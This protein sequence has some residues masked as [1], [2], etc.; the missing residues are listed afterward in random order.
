MQVECIT[1]SLLECY[2][3]M[4]PCFALS[5]NGGAKLIIFTQKAF[6]K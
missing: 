3:E 6:R 1:L 4:P 5:L 2:A